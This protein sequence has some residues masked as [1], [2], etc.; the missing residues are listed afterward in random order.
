MLNLFHL[1]IVSTA[2]EILKIVKFFRRA[3]QNI[4]LIR[5]E[6]GLGPCNVS[7][8]GHRLLKGALLIYYHGRNGLRLQNVMHDFLPFLEAVHFELFVVQQMPCFLLV[9]QAGGYAHYREVM[10][11]RVENDRLQLI[12]C[13]E[14]GLI[15]HVLWRV[16]IGYEAL[17][18][19]RRHDHERVRSCAVL[20]HPREV[21][22]QKAGERLLQHVLE[23]ERLLLA[24]FFGTLDNA[25]F[26]RSHLEDLEELAANKLD[27]RQVVL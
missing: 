4:E 21:E 12:H 1:F 11:S 27:L 10:V 22:C 25:Q 13:L 18:R 5:V 15:L 8:F 9:T 16:K 17:P 2:H 24:A 20:G 26:L 14:N 23:L 7:S 19:E 3:V 6:R